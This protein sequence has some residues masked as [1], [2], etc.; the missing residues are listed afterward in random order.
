[1]PYA[2]SMAGGYQTQV[3]CGQHMRSTLHSQVC[4]ATPSLASP[5]VLSVGSLIILMAT[6]LPC[7]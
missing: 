3:R 2:C 1:M 4:L 5:A 6:W 7:Q